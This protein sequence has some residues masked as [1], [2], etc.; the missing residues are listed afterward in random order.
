M[1]G[2]GVHFAVSEPELERLLAARGDDAV[3]EEVQKIEE[4]WEKA[5]LIET[6]GPS[7]MVSRTDRSPDLTMRPN[8][9]APLI[10]GH[11]SATALH[12]AGAI[13]AADARALATADT[14]FRTEYAPFT[15]NHF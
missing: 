9:L 13:E 1:P 2:R 6:D 11:T 8:G 12:R 15:P 5:W 10:S 14:L 4:R 7:A 3:M